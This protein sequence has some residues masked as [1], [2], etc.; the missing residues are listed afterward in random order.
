MKKSILACLVLIAG[1]GN[2]T[3]EG[4]PEVE[5]DPVF[6]LMQQFNFATAVTM[7]NAAVIG[8]EVPTRMYIDFSSYSTIRAQFVASTASALVQMRFEYS[9]N[10]GGAWSTLIP[11]LTASAVANTAV[12]SSYIDIPDDA[13]R[14]VLVRA[15]VIGNGVL[16]PI[17][18]VTLDV[19][20]S[21]TGVTE[22]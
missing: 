5:P 20:G 16:D 15:L 11:T 2:P 10:D 7:T 17:C 1:C 22:E 19:A 4:I 6:P 21:T 12:K 18:G 13:K 8:T 14:E 3:L 9:T